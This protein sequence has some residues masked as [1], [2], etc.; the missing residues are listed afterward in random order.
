M[1]GPPL[2]RRD[3]D[4][5]PDWWAPYKTEFPQWRAWSGLNHQCW[6]RLPGTLRVYHADD[7]AGL[8]GQLR[9]AHVD[10]AR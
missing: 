7:P 4:T 5:P 9:A 1:T 10:A 2:P 6:V 8:A 3:D